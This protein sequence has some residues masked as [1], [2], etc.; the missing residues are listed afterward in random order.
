MSTSAIIALITAGAALLGHLIPRKP[1]TPNTPTPNTSTPK[2]PTPDDGSD[3]FSKLPGLPGHPL[4]NWIF[5]K[6]QEQTQR[7][8]QATFD[9]FA[10]DSLVGFLNTDPQAKAQVLTKLGG[11]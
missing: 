3:P 9:S 10:V 11:K 5:K 7:E 1:A 6:K 8:Q 4:L 2:T